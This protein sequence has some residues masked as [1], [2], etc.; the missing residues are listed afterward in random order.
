LATFRN[1]PI[2]FQCYGRQA[3]CIQR[4]GVDVHD[5]ELLD[6]LLSTQAAYNKILDV[7]VGS[8]AMAFVRKPFAQLLFERLG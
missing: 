5:R 1:R 3:D 6:D 8:G 2:I 7:P 4:G